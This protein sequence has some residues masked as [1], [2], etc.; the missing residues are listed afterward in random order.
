MP[1]KTRLTPELQKQ[2]CGFVNAGAPIPH[3]CE[4]AGVPWYTCKD[5]LKKGRAGRRPYAE[6]V[7]AIEEAKGKWVA[8]ATMRITKAS[9]EDWRAAAWLLERRV[10]E[11]RPPLQQTELAVA[12]KLD[13]T[14]SA[15]ASVTAKLDELRK[16]HREP[17]PG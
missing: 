17:E 9:A 11:F 12:G 4:A 3:A 15:K 7:E 8:G 14:T 6:F 13:I 2:I 16:R 10:E 5:W 1:R